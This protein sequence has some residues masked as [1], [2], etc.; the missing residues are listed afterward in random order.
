MGLCP[1]PL[2][3]YGHVRCIWPVLANPIWPTHIWPTHLANPPGQPIWPTHIW[4]TLSGQ[5]YLAN[6]VWP[7]LSGQ[8]YLANP[9]WPTHS[10]PVLANPR[11]H[12]FKHSA[13]LCCP[14]PKHFHPYTIYHIPYIKCS[15]LV[16]ITIHPLYDSTLLCCP[17]SKQIPFTHYTTPHSCRTTSP[18][19]T[20]FATNNAHHT[21]PDTTPDKTSHLTQHV[22]RNT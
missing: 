1:P 10:W 15:A 2:Q 21:T 22:S 17:P 8:P 5:P 11:Y 20:A 12:P 19:A 4:P 7:T 14:P 3:I 18:P 13:P 16:V 9:I 6:P